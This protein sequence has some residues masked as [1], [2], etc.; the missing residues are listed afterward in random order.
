MP[1]SLSEPTKSVQ[2]K[3]E[4]VVN[5]HNNRSEQQQVDVFEFISSEVTKENTVTKE[6]QEKE[7]QER[8]ARQE[9]LEGRYNS[10]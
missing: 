5:K 7:E 6:E 1:Q 4:D 9:R 10:F 8:A 2:K 3:G